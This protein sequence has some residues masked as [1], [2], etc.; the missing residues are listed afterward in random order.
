M[1]RRAFKMFDLSLT[2]GRVAS[3]LVS[4]PKSS[5]GDIALGVSKP[6]SEHCD[7]GKKVSAFGMR[8]DG[9]RRDKHS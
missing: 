4:T 5:S 3:A 8:F 7:I 9:V 2:F 6:C 1:Q